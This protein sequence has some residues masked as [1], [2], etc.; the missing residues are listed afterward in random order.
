MRKA[1]S[2]TSVHVDEEDHNHYHFCRGHYYHFHHNYHVTSG[3]CQHNLL[4]NYIY[5]IIKLKFLMTAA[6]SYAWQTFETS[7]FA[8]NFIKTSPKNPKG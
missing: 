5:L 1:I 3:H 8:K 6:P 7:M 2:R 4:P